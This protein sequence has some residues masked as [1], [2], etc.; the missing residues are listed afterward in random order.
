MERAG[1][2]H[3]EQAD[4][5]FRV[6][7]AGDG[8]VGKT[9]LLSRLITQT[10][11]SAAVLNGEYEPT[12]FHG[13]VE[14]WFYKNHPLEVELWDTAGQSALQPLRELAYHGMVCPAHSLALCIE[15]H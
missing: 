14:H 4:F 7:V 10:T 6:V 13:H 3:E 12:T 8:A 9:A 2:I 11:G 15:R 1:T 5:T